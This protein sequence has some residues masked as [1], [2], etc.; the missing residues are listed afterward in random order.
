MQVS[1]SKCACVKFVPQMWQPTKCADC[2]H[3]LAV[4][5]DGE[6]SN[7]PPDALLTRSVQR[8]SSNNSSSSST[9]VIAPPASPKPPLPVKK[10]A[11]PTAREARETVAVPVAA[12]V[13]PKPLP[14]LPPKKRA[15]TAAQAPVDIAPVF[16]TLYTAFQPL[17]GS[18]TTDVLR[19]FRQSLTLFAMSVPPQF[20]EI[21]RNDTKVLASELVTTLLLAVGVPRDKV[22]SMVNILVIPALADVPSVV[23]AQSL[24]ELRLIAADLRRFAAANRIVRGVTRLQAL[25]RG[26]QT[27]R[28]LARVTGRS[29]EPLR[30][31]LAA[32]AIALRTERTFVADLRTLTESYV[33]P[34]RKL[35]LL[36]PAEQEALFGNVEQLEMSHTVLLA[37][38]EQV[39]ARWPFVD[40]ALADAISRAAPQFEQQA[41]PF[42]RNYA[43]SLKQLQDSRT[44]N[45]KFVQ[46]LERTHA[47]VDAERNNLYA[48]VDSLLS[49]P[50]NRLNTYVRLLTTF[51][52]DF[53]CE[54][55][56][57][58]AQLAD[59]L[60][61]VTRVTATMFE[62][63]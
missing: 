59:A 21:A 52:A 41:I 9:S 42:A 16:G 22:D 3:T 24:D 48:G 44:G 55:A 49:V 14:V 51:V 27:R 13:T 50:V 5:V 2:F 32:F 12:A 57:E 4:H 33:R 10:A 61:Q 11:R 20:R 63:M 34:L 15:S 35:Q 23:P 17:R 36:S 19:D 54:S 45:A 30:R 38:L 8:N 26:A 56:S 53:P 46:W 47:R 1:C 37:D 58:K 62:T 6:S 7:A 25:F 31:C 40:A 28:R 18:L 60:A 39:S 43:R 29:R